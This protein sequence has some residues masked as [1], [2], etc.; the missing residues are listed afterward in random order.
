MYHTG[1]ETHQ[2]AILAEIVIWRS[3]VTLALSVPLIAYCSYFYGIKRV[4]NLQKKG[5]HATMFALMFFCGVFYAVSACF[6]LLSTTNDLTDN[7]VL[8]K[9][10]TALL[11]GGIAWL[12]NLLLH[13]QF[14]IKYWLVSQRIEATLL[15]LSDKTSRKTEL[16]AKFTAFLLVLCIFVLTSL[17]VYF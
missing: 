1:Q 11:T 5:F 4:V 7:Q 2:N 12:L 14:V 13:T 15:Q 10:R 17:V 16:H 8:K 9:A 6:E 3:S